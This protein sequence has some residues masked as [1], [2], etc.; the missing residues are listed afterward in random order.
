MSHAFS[1]SDRQSELL[2]DLAM[3]GLSHA[4]LRELEALGLADDTFDLAAAAADLAMF[5]PAEPLPDHVRAKL[6]ACADRYIANPGGD[7]V[8]AR[9]TP[10]RA[11]AQVSPALTPKLAGESVARVPMVAKLGWVAAAACLGLAIVGWMPKPGKAGRGTEILAGGG[12]LG[13]QRNQLL[14]AGEDVVRFDW[15]DWAA[16]G[17]GPEIPGVKGDVVF[18]PKTQTGYMRF[19]G[20]PDNPKDAQYQLWIVDERGM[21]QRV[22]GAIFDAHARGGELIVPVSPRITVGKPVA[23]ALTIEKPGGTWV[24]DMKRRVVIATAKG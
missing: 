21:G 19:V 7:A 1:N 3:Q 9:I 15:S 4:E 11:S 2:A 24:S 5:P 6:E 18:S 22:S 12:D 10:E 16:D 20:L 13:T 14:A 8:I 23:F 17:Q